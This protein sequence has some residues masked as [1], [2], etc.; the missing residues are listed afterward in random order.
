MFRLCVLMHVIKACPFLSRV[1]PGPAD[2]TD[3]KAA[4]ETACGIMFR[5]GEPGRRAPRS[6]A[7]RITSFEA[8]RPFSPNTIE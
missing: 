8:L 3:T 1:K 6:R 4:M 7:I 5:Y 2:S